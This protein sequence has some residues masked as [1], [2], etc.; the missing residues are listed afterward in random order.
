MSVVR[1]NLLN[2]EGYVPYCGNG[3]CILG[4]PRAHFDGK[5]FACHC[6]WRSN[7]EPE[8]IAEY[9]AKWGKSP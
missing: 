5:Q 2:R 6:G 7:F 8:F 9:K 3:M 4:M 1:D